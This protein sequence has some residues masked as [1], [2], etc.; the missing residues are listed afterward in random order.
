MVY[1]YFP[2]CAAFAKAAQICAPK[3]NQKLARLAPHILLGRQ[4]GEILGGPDE[5]IQIIRLSRRH[6]FRGSLFLRWLE[7]QMLQKDVVKIAALR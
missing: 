4:A 3:I 2:V 6:S 1:H 5:G 7:V